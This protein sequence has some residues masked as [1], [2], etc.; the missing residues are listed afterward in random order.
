MYMFD[1]IVEIT[2]D[3]MQVTIDDVKASD[4]DEN[5]KLARM[6]ICYF[7]IKSNYTLSEVS[8]KLQINITRAW[9]NSRYLKERMQKS[10]TTKYVF[11]RIKERLSC[12]K[13]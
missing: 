2:L 7:A 11:N 9:N 10:A 13:R 8:D 5:A 4:K 6:I 12:F 3:E 1:K